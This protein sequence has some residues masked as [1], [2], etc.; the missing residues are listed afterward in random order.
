MTAT[1]EAQ[2]KMRVF[3]GEAGQVAHARD[4][5]ERVLA[6]HPVADDAVLL[7][8]ELAANA[9]V[10]TASG[11]GGRFMVTVRRRAVGVRVE[12]WDEGA[13][14]VPVVQS[15]DHERESGVGLSLVDMIATRWGHS[16]GRHRGLVW[17]EIEGK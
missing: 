10:H 6:G 2:P 5:V 15:P 8:S 1:V 4:F 17:F 14:T 13:P 16:G 12:V 11:D 9:I 3:P 7:T